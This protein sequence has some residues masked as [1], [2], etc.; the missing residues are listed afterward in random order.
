MT[1]G[2]ESVN[3]EPRL[4]VG[5]SLA[6]ILVCAIAAGFGARG[7]DRAVAQAGAAEPAVTDRAAAHEVNG[8]AAAQTPK[9]AIWGLASHNGKSMFP[10]YRDLG[11]G[12]WQTQARWDQIAPLGR[13][14]QPTDPDDPEYRWPRYMEQAIAEAERY[15]MEVTIQLIGTPPWANGGR[16]WIWAPTQPSDFADFA[17][18]IARKFPS[19]NLWMVWGEPNR[20]ENFAPFTAAKPTAKKLTKKQA[21]APRVYSQLLDAAYGALKAD[22]PANLVIGGSTYFTG[23][24]GTIRPYPWIRHMRLPGGA[25]PRMDMWGHN[26]YSYRKPKLKSRPSPLGRVDF[27]DLGRLA[28]ALDRAFPGPRLRLFL[29][30]WGVPTGNQD[31]DFRF[32]VSSETSVKWIRAAFRIVRGWDRVYTLGWSVPVDNPTNSQ[33]LLYSDLYPK[34]GYYAFKEG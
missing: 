7:P 23:G 5:V 29:S 15:G 21:R 30:E 31:V 1:L 33:G 24:K 11:V 22:S 26:P 16:D 13:P 32:R 14:A 4:R 9:K 34:P 27:S 28:K 6:L 10:T 8:T 17:T 3:R 18:A 20:D 12:I 25:R 2:S 19:V